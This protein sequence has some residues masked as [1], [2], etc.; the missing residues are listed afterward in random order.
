MHS[1][2]NLGSFQN[3]MICSMSPQK[4]RSLR[5]T[6]LRF[7]GRNLSSSSFDGK[8]IKAAAVADTGGGTAAA[9]G[10][11]QRDVTERRGGAFLTAEF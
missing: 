2:K 9:A 11:A 3:L 10:A 7:S 8:A 1:Y 4:R 6:S 5:D